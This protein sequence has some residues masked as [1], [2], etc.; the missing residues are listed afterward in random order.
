MIPTTTTK[1]KRRLVQI[2][3]KCCNG[4]NRD[5][6][7]HKFHTASYL[8]EEA[9]LLSPRVYFIPLRKDYIQMS[10]FFGTFKWESQIGTFAIPKLWML[11]FFSNKIIFESLK[12]ISYSLWKYLSN[13]VKHVPTKFYLTPAFKDLWLAIK[14]SIWLP[15]LLLIITHANQV[16]M[17][18]ARAF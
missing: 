3:W 5:N 14:F 16:Y 10:F 18:N 7:K 1:K 12:T 2:K 9:P 15:P 4:F 13:G 17:N 8:W 6:F 11:I